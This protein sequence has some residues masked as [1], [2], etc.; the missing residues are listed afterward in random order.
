MSYSRL[1]QSHHEDGHQVTK[2][3]NLWQ[4]GGDAERVES[5]ENNSKD[6]TTH[7]KK[8]NTEGEGVALRIRCEEEIEAPVERKEKEATPPVTPTQ[9]KPGV[10]VLIDA[11]Q[12]QVFP[13]TTHEEQKMMIQASIENA[14]DVNKDEVLVA[15]QLRI[16]N[17]TTG[18]KEKPTSGKGGAMRPPKGRSKGKGGKSRRWR[19]PTG[20]ALH[21][22]EE[23]LTA[24]DDSC[25]YTAD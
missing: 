10:E 12:R 11:I 1:V 6:L 16:Q 8:T 9:V 19:D 13:I 7:W 17:R 3:G 21:V 4:S 22:S 20:F 24:M 5:E 25:G 23:M 18:G 15:Q 14:Q 2:S